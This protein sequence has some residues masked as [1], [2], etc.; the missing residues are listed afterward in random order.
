MSRWGAL[1]CWPLWLAVVPL[2]LWTFVRELGLERGY[3]LVAVIAFTP[4]VALGGFFLAGLALALRNWPAAAT[5]AL[6]T[7]LLALAVLPRVV[8]DGSARAEPGASELRIL[9]A[10]I[11]HG[12]ADPDD[13]VALVDRLDADVLTLPELT[14]RFERRLRAAGLEERLPESVVSVADPADG[15]VRASGNGVYSS[16]PLRKLP[17][18]LADADAFR[19]PR[20]AVAVGGELVRLVAVHPWPPT[21]EMVGRWRAALESLPPAGRGSPWVLAGDFNA[22]ID[23]AELRSVL[24]RGYVDA[25]AETG[26]GLE[27]TWPAGRTLPPLIAID[28]VLADERLAVLG[29]GVE[30]LPGSDHRAVF[31]TLAVP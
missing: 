25:A 12:T 10:N 9:A 31:A 5:A 22:T 21:G 2:L 15:A 8:G 17:E 30:D 3:P 29:F 18:G 28:H 7:L 27:P 1:R 26:Q 6:A 20:V 23:H 24:D 13:L 19:Q 16:L 14:A 11:H 4:Y